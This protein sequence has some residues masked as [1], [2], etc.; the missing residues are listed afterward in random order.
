MINFYQL[1]TKISSIKFAISL[2]IFIAISSSIGTFIP[3]EKG[4]QEYLDLY[5]ATPFLV[6]LNGE[7][8]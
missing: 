5:D 3:Q 6:F 2:L 8:I 1:I 4:L 7:K